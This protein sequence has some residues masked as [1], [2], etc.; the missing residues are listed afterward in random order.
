MEYKFELKV[1][2]YGKAIEV[3]IL[4]ENDNNDSM[5]LESQKEIKAVI[6]MLQSYLIE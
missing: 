5:F 6:E 2:H 4:R 1:N 3:V